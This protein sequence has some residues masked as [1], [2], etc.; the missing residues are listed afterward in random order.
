MYKLYNLSKPMKFYTGGKS[1]GQMLI[2][3]KSSVQYGNIV[4]VLAEEGM[5]YM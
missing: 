2:Y 1:N 4:Q 5:Q 3:M